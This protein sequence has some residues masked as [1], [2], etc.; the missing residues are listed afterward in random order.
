M[1]G[2]TSPNYHLSDFHTCEGCGRKDKDVHVA[3][4]ITL[5]WKVCPECFKILKANLADRQVRLAGLN[6]AV[7]NAKDELQMWRERA[8]AAEL[9]LEAFKHPF[10]I[11]RGQS[12]PW[13][14]MLPHNDMCKRNHGG[15]DLQRIAERGGLYPAEA[16][17]VVNDLVYHEADKKFSIEYMTEQWREFA[18]KVNNP[19]TACIVRQYKI[20]VRHIR[21]AVADGWEEKA[22]R[23]GGDVPCPVCGIEYREHPKVESGIV[24]DCTGKL[25]KL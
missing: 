2:E 21:P 24:A 9:K 8:L 12:V 13:S 17:C 25:W 6:K 15:Q 7:A 20:L 3:S 14:V 4:S 18:E 23:A 16:F 1:Y 11:M 10:P 5:A 22:E 19:V